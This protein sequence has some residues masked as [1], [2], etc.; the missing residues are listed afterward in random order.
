MK[1]KT[2]CKKKKWRPLA[3]LNG[4][5]KMA[6]RCVAIRILKKGYLLNN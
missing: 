4:V 5:Y 6:S 1:T 3:L 2:I